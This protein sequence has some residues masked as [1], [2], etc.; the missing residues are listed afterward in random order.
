[1]RKNFKLKKG[2]ANKLKVITAS[3]LALVIAF[4]AISSN[5]FLFAYSQDDIIATYNIGVDG[6]NVKATLRTSGILSITGTGDT[7]DYTADTMPFS[8]N[9]DKITSVEIEDGITSLGDYL[10]F[11]CKNLNDKLELPATI[12]SIGD[13]AF[14]GYSKEAAPTFTYINNKF[15]SADISVPVT[16]TEEV[17]SQTESV[18]PKQEEPQ[19]E[20]T[21][22]PVDEN[23]KPTEETKPQET[24]EQPQT[25]EVTTMEIKT[26]T[27]QEIGTDIF[28]EGQTG[29]YKADKGN[30]SFR[31]A[32]E[33][34]GYIEADRFITVSL[35]GVIT[36]TLPVKDGK[37]TVPNLPNFGIVSPE[38]DDAYTTHTFTNW[39]YEN[40]A[41]HPSDQM[42]VSD[43]ADKITLTSNWNT[44]WKINPQVKTEAK[45]EI[46][47]YS[48][49]D[50][51]TG[52]ALAKA[53]GYALSVQWQINKGDEKNEKEWKDIDGAT[54]LTYERKV[55][56]GDTS[57]HFRAKISILRQVK[58]RSI[59]EP[60]VMTT[61]AVAGINSLTPITVTYE[62]N[63]GFGTIASVDIK[64]G[65]NY[66]P[67]ENTF[68]APSGQVF[69]G[70]KVTLNNVT[71][72]KNDGS[73]INTNDIIKS[74]EP[75][76]T[77]LVSGQT[78]GSVTLTAQWST[79]V[80]I[81]LDSVNG[82]DTNDGLSEGTAVKT[83]NKA[84]EL[85]PSDGMMETN[86][87]I[88]CNNYSLSGR[89]ILPAKN[90]TITSLSKESKATLQ[91]GIIQNDG[92]NTNNLLRFQGDIKFENITLSST[93]TRSTH[94]EVSAIYM[95]GKH[96]IAGENVSTINKISIYG[97]SYDN[98]TLDHTQIDIYSGDWSYVYGGSYL[99]TISK[100]T[101]VN[102]YGG[103]V[104]SLYQGCGY[105]NNGN[106]VIK[107]FVNGSTNTSIY[108]G[109]IRLT[110]AM[111]GG[112]TS[113]NN[114]D[115]G[116]KLIVYNG[117]IATIYGGSTQPNYGVVVKKSIIIIYAGTI[118]SII[119][120]A[121]DSSTR[122]GQNSGVS[123][124]LYKDVH[125]SGDVKCGSNDNM[126]SATTAI[127]L[128]GDKELYIYGATI[129]G[130]IYGGC[131]RGSTK[132]GVVKIFLEEGTVNNIYGGGKG[133]GN[134]SAQVI[135]NVNIIVGKNGIVKNNIYGGANY[136]GLVT[137][138]ISITM[139]GKAN[140]VYG[141][142]NGSL[143]SV[144]GST[145]VE[146][147]SGE[148]SNI[149]GGGESGTLSGESSVKVTGGTIGNV[150]VSGNIFGAGNN[151]GVT[152]S[153]IT[154]EGTPTITGNIYGG[155]NAS[156]T[157]TTS[158]VNIK[159][160]VVKNVY[161]G[162]KG[163]GT[164]V[165]NANLNVETGANI[166]GNTF[167]GSEEG[168]VTNSV[169]NLNGGTAAN[170]FGGSD[171]ASVTDSVK[172][173]SLAGSN[174]IN[175]YAGCN[176]SGSVKNPILNLAGKAINVF[177][178]GNATPNTSEDV[179]GIST[180]NVTSNQANTIKNV[181]GGANNTGKVTSPQINISGYV[182]N[183]YGGGLG[184]NTITNTPL[185]NIK[186]GGNVTGSV[187]GGGEEGKV[188]GTT[189]T[190]ENGSIVKNAF[191][192]GNKVG[193]DGTIKIDSQTGSQAINVYGGSNSSGTLSSPT[194]NINGTVENTYG[195]GE[196]GAVAGT[197][198]TLESG[199]TVKNAF[200][201]GNKAGVTGTIKLITQSGSKATNIYGGS[202]SSG[203]VAKPILEIA[204]D[205]TNIYGGGFEGVTNSGNNIGTIVDTPAITVTGGTITNIYGGGEKGPTVS[206]N[207]IT[208][209][210]GNI[211]NVFGGGKSASSD[212]TSIKLENNSN[213]IGSS[214]TNIYG[215]SESSGVTKKSNIEV[216][217]NVTNVFGGGKGQNTK[218]TE[219]YI[220]T[221]K[222]SKAEY[223]YGGSEQGT[224]SKAT[225]IVMGPVEKSIYGGGLGAT[226]TVTGDTWVFVS[227]DVKDSVYG[228]GN[229]G[230]VEGNT[231]VDIAKGTIGS[232]G[233]DGNVFGGSNQAKVKG[234]TL[235][236]IGS[237]VVKTPTGAILPTVTEKNIDIKG[238]VFGGGNTTSTGKDFDASD[239]YVLG[240]ATVE[241]GGTDYQ[242]LKIAKSIF[243]DGNKCV[244]NGTKTINIKDYNAIGTDANQ[245]IQRASKLNIE[246]STIEIIGE[247]DSANLVTTIPYSLNRIDDLVLKNGSTLKLRNGVNLVMG[248]ESRNADDYLQT[249]TEANNDTTGNRIYLKQGEHLELRV[250]EDVSRP[251][252]GD[253]KGFAQLGRYEVDTN[254]NVTPITKNSQGVYIMGG[255]YTSDA[256]NNAS[257]F[258]V[259]ESENFDGQDP[260][261]K[262]DKITPTTNSSSW[263]NWNLGSQT[264]TIKDKL[265]I[266]DNPGNAKTAQLNTTWD[267]DGSIYRVDPD[268]VTI[269]SGFPYTIVNPDTITKNGEE[270]TIGISIE[271]GQTGWLEQSKAGYIDGNK[272]TPYK[273]T[274]SFSK[275]DSLDMRSLTVTGQS[276]I[277]NVKLYNSDNITENST[278]DAI[279]TFSIDKIAEQP[280]GS[281]IKTGKIIVEL[282]I[283][284]QTTT[285]YSHAL[286]GQGKI[287]DRAI[288]EYNF[289]TA[290]DVGTTVSQNSS[291][292]TQFVEKTQ[293]A[294]TVTGYSIEFTKAKSN[295]ILYLPQGTK[296][297]MVDRS[298]E[299]P[300]YYHYD[301]ISTTCNSVSLQDFVKN[302]NAVEKYT[303][304]TS[305][306]TK[307]NF[308]FVVDF[309]DAGSFDNSDICMS[310]NTTTSD[311]TKTSK[312]V[313]FGVTGNRREYEMKLKEDNST[314]PSV[315]SYRMNG[316][317]GLTVNSTVKSGSTTDTTG[318]D[319]QMA[320]R[321]QLKLTNT[322][323]DAIIPIPPGWQIQS[324]GT[325]YSTSGDSATVLL[326]NSLTVAKSDIY[327]IMSNMG[328]IPAGNYMLEITLVGGAMANYPDRALSTT[329]AKYKFKLIDDR[330]SIQAAITD[331]ARQIFAKSDK[332][333]IQDYTLLRV[334]DGRS[335]TSSIKTKLTLWKKDSGTYGQVQIK[336]Y[337]DSINGA[338]IGALKPLTIDPTNNCVYLPWSTMY[339]LQ[340]K[341]K[342]NIGPGTYQWRYTITQTTGSSQTETELATEKNTFIIT[343]D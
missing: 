61:D 317:F 326:A 92:Y 329:I 213:K 238:T 97:G 150:G 320:A 336:D 253:V 285:T 223:V 266:S 335:D 288:Q 269:S 324:N 147:F 166:K 169:V 91:T 62:S 3:I 182:E 79:E 343:N 202:N 49:I 106:D 318:S 208:I 181:Y 257:G 52:K 325:R 71:A 34:A 38:Q 172:I 145:S 234:N 155:S 267:A 254:G 112:K 218:V 232:T 274:T 11:G 22:T 174:A 300:V 119:G 109:E 160:T 107:G 126:T 271:T 226:S 120:G 9:I 195:G 251:G 36:Q 95:Y 76:N 287:Y 40:V 186:S 152:T 159:G 196:E 330:Y 199:S 239:P 164:T 280:D 178:G 242:S 84:Y 117:K 259:A 268:S 216:N 303:L 108:G 55:E 293:T 4:Q 315:P 170:V 295:D 265:I 105:G 332:D 59:N 201:G 77:S 305:A 20:N 53:D 240:N 2:V 247:V 165:T 229:E 248:F 188:T 314:A 220:M 328:N 299:N 86:K 310:F 68:T 29:G 261:N 256:D 114:H 198:V 37:M 28:F 146:M 212:N 322:T 341:L 297:L 44:E 192:G 313:R 206:T 140:N 143:T 56:S 189:V 33:K 255:L 243:G 301:V 190:L 304:P 124:T 12:T 129:D 236:H 283:S 323:T 134:K 162:G 72:T 163:S 319:K 230:G 1:M 222:N 137:G 73:A 67:E 215:G 211:T 14:S 70:W 180:I 64:D 30:K 74:Y 113:G 17:A 276:P 316:T 83:I 47:V 334:S 111:R 241:I 306:I 23:N 10:F 127:T 207:T 167:G 156:G 286:I 250:N 104:D 252:Y 246:H 43:N 210:G 225:A 7:K 272:I 136:N 191:A 184:S 138:N 284:K 25:K 338:T 244:T 75:L 50:A 45:E 193:V 340:T 98:V 203:N 13:Y 217:G 298:G 176:A 32:A 31:T 187:F 339:N 46:S 308:I 57:S 228:G 6:E 237:Y 270:N 123:I 292:T 15:T 130:D 100:D 8:N 142:G 273:T 26:I 94:F 197:T 110:N 18:E 278:N 148:V 5:G 87:L 144:N 307:N 294:K 173:N 101:N 221:L 151:V 115:Y 82:N 80:T 54:D 309:A 263:R 275:T 19:T 41:Y 194:V 81:Y 175:I 205:A 103:Y 209:S 157:T 154:L 125:V 289:N 177:G 214:V 342:S 63:G 90:T 258:V 102:I 282:T 227:N 121:A 42:E 24:T 312:K 331:E 260:V 249:V 69:T 171:K 327:V 35:D 132:D 161:A 200:A 183:T 262:G 133:E 16:K 128:L 27:E 168:V 65:A 58:T 281:E 51:N 279:V 337:L 264:I 291:V 99:G 296:I 158:N 96:F 290:G 85:L 131:N 321:V 39:S 219:T 204:G 139:E 89:T 135:G 231:H 21:E 122:V 179:E 88:L 78:N 149:Y 185:V 245:S 66:K 277:I 118:D 60:K 302:G 235:V 141:A 153:N 48:V 233:K 333:K 311:G 116:N 93:R 224:V